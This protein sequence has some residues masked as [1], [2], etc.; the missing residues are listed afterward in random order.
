VLANLLAVCRF[1]HDVLQG[2]LPTVVQLA[3]KLLADPDTYDV[4]AVNQLRKRAED[5][6]THQEVKLW[7]EF[8]RAM[9]G[10]K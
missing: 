8:I 5:S 9:R 10:D 3:F 1:C 4:Q 2:W 7:A 6:I